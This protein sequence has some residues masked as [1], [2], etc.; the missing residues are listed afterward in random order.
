MTSPFQSEKWQDLTA[1]FGFEDI[2]YHRA[3]NQPTLRVAFNRPECLNAFR[4]KTVDELLVALEDAKQQQDVGYVIITGNGPDPKH[5]RWS[6]SSG[7][8]QR[9][10]GKDGY[11][12]EEMDGVS[13]RERARLGRLHILDVQRCI[14]FM[15][16]VVIAVVP[17]VQQQHLAK[18]LVVLHFVV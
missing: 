3:L 1:E 16:K 8:D 15:P 7:G 18:I 11:Q 10:R 2:T 14:R 17:Q 5:G 9:I 12:Y 4:P 6:F 13:R